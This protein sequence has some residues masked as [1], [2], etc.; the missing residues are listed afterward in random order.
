MNLSLISSFLIGGLLLLMLIK[1]NVGMVETSA[2]S[3]SDQLAK[4]NID[5]VADIISY[6]MRKIGYGVQN[7]KILSISE[8]AITFQSDLDNNKG[9]KQVTWHFDKTQ[10]NNATQNPDDYILF[11]KVD[12]VDEPVGMGVTQFRMIYYDAANNETSDITAVARIKVKLVC[13]SSEPVDGQ[14]QKTA[15]EKTFTPLNLHI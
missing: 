10:S 12:G 2:E 6:D 5:A 3:M 14:Y 7:Q 15:W 13:Q 4:Q 9:V 11:R 1:T 8:D